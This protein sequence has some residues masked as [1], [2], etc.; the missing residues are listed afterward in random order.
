MQISVYISATLRAFVNKKAKLESE[1]TTVKEILEQLQ[2]EYP[3]SKDALFEEDRFPNAIAIPIRQLA[4]RQK[5]LDADVDTVFICREG[6]RSILAINT[7]RE[8]GY[9][10]PMYNLKGGIEAA[11]NIIF[12]HEGA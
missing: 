4:R 3:E 6:K 11:K 7:L 1:G 12:S 10:G 2:E 9:K 5:E 8:A